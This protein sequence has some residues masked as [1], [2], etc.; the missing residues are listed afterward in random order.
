MPP[1]EFGMP[2]FGMPRFWD[3]PR[4]PVWDAPFLGCP[5]FWDAPNF[6]DAPLQILGCPPIHPPIEFW[7]APIYSGMP[8]LIFP[9]IECSYFWDAPILG[10]PCFGMPL[11]LECPYFG[12]PLILWMPLFRFW[13]APRMPGTLAVCREVELSKGSQKTRTWFAHC[14]YCAKQLLSLSHRPWTL[15]PDSLRFF[16]QYE[17]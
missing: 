16:A 4:C 14:S 5:Y 13:D 3:A 2:L 17:Q 8:P 11:F 1:D 10:C 12:M 9:S 15:S 7:D 6:W